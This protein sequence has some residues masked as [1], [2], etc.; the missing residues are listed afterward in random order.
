MVFK[1]RKKFS[2]L[3]GFS[4][5]TEVLYRIYKFKKTENISF[6]FK[7][8]GFIT[9]T[10]PFKQTKNAKLYNFCLKYCD[11]HRLT[12][13]RQGKCRFERHAGRNR[14]AASFDLSV[15]ANAA[16]RGEKNPPGSACFCPFVTPF[17]LTLRNCFFIINPCR[18]FG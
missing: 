3:S 8:F 6:E 12:S 5:N 7:V 17:P 14:K 1:K 2:E 18:S 9:H 10:M 15:C 16:R 4:S 13:E 11:V